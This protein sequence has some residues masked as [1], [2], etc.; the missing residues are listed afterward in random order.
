M[1][2]TENLIRFIKILL[3][4]WLALCACKAFAQRIIHVKH[5]TYEILYNQDLMTPECVYY[6]LQASDFA[7]SI[8]KKP[9]YF[10]QDTKLPAPRRKDKHF[11][12]TDYQRGHLCPSGDR[13]SRT[14]WFKDTFYTSN[15]VPMTPQ[16]NSGMWKEIENECRTLA[17]EGHKLKIACG[18]ITHSQG[19]CNTTPE[20]YYIPDTLWKV[21]KCIECDT[22]HRAW[23]VPNCRKIVLHPECD[24]STTE[25]FQ[26]LTPVVAQFIKLWIN[27]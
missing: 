2:Q 24:T 19:R 8:T 23:M 15:I 5:Q 12:F 18:C 21:A 20:S 10:K 13:D 27:Q 16:V 26:S 6:T 4:L 3:I 7:G 1:R 9:K 14:D 17:I 22:I 25:I 11:R